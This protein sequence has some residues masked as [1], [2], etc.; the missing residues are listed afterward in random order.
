[1]IDPRLRTL[2]VFDECGTV[3][4]TAELTGLSPSAVSAQL[5]EL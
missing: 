1:M 4:G 2:R 3:S 5:R